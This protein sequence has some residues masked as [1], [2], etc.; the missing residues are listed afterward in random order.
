MKITVGLATITMIII[1]CI[2]ISACSAQKTEPEEQ[3]YRVEITEKEVELLIGVYGEEEANSIR[4]GNLIQTKYKALN[5]LRA[6]EKY[7]KDKYRGREFKTTYLCPSNIYN[8]RAYI[9][10][11]D[12]ND[13]EENIY[14]V[15]IESKTNTNGET[16]YS[17]TDDYYGKILREVYDTRIEV[18][19][20]CEN[21]LGVK[22]Y[23]IFNSPKGINIGKEGMSAEEI[24]NMGTELPKHTELFAYQP[25]IEEIKSLMEREKIYA[26]FTVYSVEFDDLKEGIGELLDKKADY[27][28]VQF[29]TFAI[30]N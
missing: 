26:R 23:T 28:S 27:N 10:V 20:N 16:E 12:C 18:I 13:K 5:E 8:P 15:W 3:V 25:D 24:I 22:S 9:Y 17:C 2:N 14:T 29:D 30:F 11:T 6:G 1:T 4:K 7:L 19:L 21:I